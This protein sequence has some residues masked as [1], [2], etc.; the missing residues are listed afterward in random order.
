MERL[1]EKEAAKY[2]IVDT[3]KVVPLYPTGIG[4][5]GHREAVLITFYFA[6]PEHENRMHVLARVGLT[7]ELAESLINSLKEGVEKSKKLTQE[8]KQKK[9]S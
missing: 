5:A 2:E 3:G 6:P 9:P 4:L 1:S 8:E 7:I